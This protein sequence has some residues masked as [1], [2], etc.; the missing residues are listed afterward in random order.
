MIYHT[1]LYSQTYEEQN[2][3]FTSNPQLFSL[4]FVKIVI[5][6]EWIRIFV[7]R[8]T[9]NFVFWASY[10]NLACT[11][12]QYTWNIFISGKCSRANTGTENLMI[13]VVS[14]STDVFAFLIPQKAI[15]KLQTSTNR[16]ATISAIFAAGIVAVAA[17]SARLAMALILGHCPDFTYHSTSVIL[18]G[19]AE[20]TCAFLV[21]CI[22]AL[23]KAFTYTKTSEAIS[24][25]YSWVRMQTLRKSSKGGTSR[26]WPR[27]ETTQ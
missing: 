15:W 14:L 10:S 2:V 23:P 22:P 12:H 11:P 20:M 1:Y 27:R 6:L 25:L 5:L 18:C 13:S 3:W 8:G 16:K 9:R 4:T 26:K 24:S 21:I 7:P 19:L 17:A